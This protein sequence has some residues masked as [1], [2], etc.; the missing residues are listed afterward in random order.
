MSSFNPALPESWA[1]LGAAW[2][3]TTGREPNQ[4]ELMGFLAT[5]QLPDASGMSM[6]MGGMGMMGMNGMGMGMGM[7]GMG[8]MGMGRQ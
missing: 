7:G 3:V 6:G 8:D 2:K 1:A 4:M 5:G